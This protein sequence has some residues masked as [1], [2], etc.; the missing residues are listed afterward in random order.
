LAGPDEEVCIGDAPFQLQG[1][2][3]AGGRWT[4][5]GVDAA[6]L[7][8]PAAGGAGVHTL[9]YSFTCQSGSVTAATK[10]IRVVDVEGIPGIKQ[11]GLDSLV[12]DMVGAQYEWEANGK[13]LRSTVNRIR[14]QEPGFYKVRVLDGKCASEFSDSFAA[15]FYSDFQV[16]PNPSHGVITVSGPTLEE[17]LEIVIFNS[18]GQRVF[19]RRMST[20]TGKAQLTLNLLKPDL[21]LIT[22]KTSKLNKVLKLAMIQ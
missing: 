14:I 6:G 10:R 20:F 15:S 12:A 9:T 16:F 1:A 2:A 7:F 21:Y 17:A 5:I 18:I 13:T 19:S 3:P 4:G 22:L 8:N 11:V